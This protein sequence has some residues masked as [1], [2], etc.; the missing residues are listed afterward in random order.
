MLELADVVAST[1]GMLRR[2]ATDPARTFIVAT[3][4]GLVD[5]MRTLY[6]DRSFV[7]ASRR[8]Y[9]PNMKLTTL[10]KAITALDEGVDEITVPQRIRELALRAVERMVETR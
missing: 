4:V 6:P 7:V 10:D 1:S 2:P 9:C 3:E 5:R 8:A